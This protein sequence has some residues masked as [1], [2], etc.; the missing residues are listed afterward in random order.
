MQF[1]AVMGR[2]YRIVNF[3]IGDNLHGPP[4]PPRVR[5]NFENSDIV[6]QQLDRN[7]T[8]TSDDNAFVPRSW[9]WKYHDIKRVDVFVLT[10]WN[11]ARTV[12]RRRAPLG[13]RLDMGESLSYVLLFSYDFVALLQ[14]FESHGVA[15]DR[16]PKKLN[17]FLIGRM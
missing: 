8:P 15:V 13:I 2:Q 6:V 9:S 10:T 5:V 1:D 16:Q 4:P 14:G 11:A 7:G 3:A 17:Y 12:D